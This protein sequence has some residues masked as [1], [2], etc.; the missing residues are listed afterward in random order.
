MMRD[1]KRPPRH[2]ISAVIASLL[3]N[4]ALLS[5]IYHLAQATAQHETLQIAV[6]L[7][8]PARVLTLPPIPQRQV[9]HIQEKQ[10]TPVVQ[11]VPA[12]TPMATPLTNMVPDIAS[13]L[14]L[15]NSPAEAPISD[16]EDD[17]EP[18]TNLNTRLIQDSLPPKNPTTT[19]PASVNGLP[20]G[21][22]STPH[23]GSAVGNPHPDA[24]T[25]GP[26]NV[27]GANHAGPGTASENGS[28]TTI[29][30]MPGSGGPNSLPGTGN[31][32]SGG[33]GP[34]TKG[35][36]Q[37]GV[38]PGSTGTATGNPGSGGD[39]PPSSPPETGGPPTTGHHPGRGGQRKA[40]VLKNAQPPYPRD[41]RDEGIEGTVVLQVSLDAQARVTAVKV[42]KSA[43]DRRLDRA[44]ERAVKG[45]TF[46]TA[47]EDGNPVASTLR[48]RVQ[49]KLE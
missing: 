36:A 40:G 23:D 20:A 35:P 15:V 7:D 38:D 22:N 18:F 46:E 14:P 13:P 2:I 21:S 42:I 3:V 44:A 10:H 5:G 8:T 24:T 25:G 29:Q 31:H 37:G 34:G 6:T 30:G 41:V 11:A 12:N 32:A 45:W 49:F 1:G 16:H 39:G 26:E 48:V 43:G 19:V 47:L 33:D 9:R 28:I 17:L 27:S 4:S